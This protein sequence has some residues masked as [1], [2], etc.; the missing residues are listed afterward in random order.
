MFFNRILSNAYVFIF[1][2]IFACENKSSRSNEKK[3][4][5]NLKAK[6]PTII[7]YK[8]ELR[9]GEKLVLENLYIDTV[10]FIETNDQGD[11][12]LFV[13][14]KDNKKVVFINNYNV[15]F[16]GNRGDVVKV[17]WKVD[18]LY[19]SGDNE[20][21]NYNEWLMKVK[22]LKDGN[23]TIFKNS[24]KKP[25]RQYYEEDLNLT[26]DYLQYL[27]N[28]VEYYV[29]NSKNEL[30]RITLADTTADLSYSIEEMDRDEKKYIV[31]GIST[32]FEHHTNIL[33]WLY[34]DAFEKIVYE[35]D[36]PADSL[37]KFY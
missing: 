25:I 9:P 37:V 20:S 5:V 3:L 17:T 36:L 21:L 30:I 6:T 11:D 32:V 13:A 22:K 19:I 23:L 8:S 27:H 12:I 26:V 29:A 1:F 33:Q 31:L 4:T 18:S 16:K 15:S 24:L 14:K 2:V 28:Q 7:N 10:E 34:F 35:Y